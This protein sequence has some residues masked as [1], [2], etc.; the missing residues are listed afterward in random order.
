[1]LSDGIAVELGDD[2]SCERNAPPA[3]PCDGGSSRA[4]GVSCGLPSFVHGLLVDP[5][6]RSLNRFC[7]QSVDNEAIIIGFSIVATR[8]PSISF[9]KIKH[10]VEFRNFGGFRACS[11]AELEGR[12]VGDGLERRVFGEILDSV[13]VHHCVKPANRSVYQGP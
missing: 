8:L 3:T 11:L 2:S 12:V 6:L 9:G 7:L 5:C 10:S 13:I 4:C 1:K